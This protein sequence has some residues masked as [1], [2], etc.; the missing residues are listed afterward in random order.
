MILMTIE[1]N[2]L[3][4]KQISTEA[5]YLSTNVQLWTCLAT[6]VQECSLIVSSYRRQPFYLKR[7]PQHKELRCC[8]QQA[9]SSLAWGGCTGEHALMRWK[10]GRRGWGNDME[11]G[12]IMSLG[13]A[14]L[15]ADIR[16]LWRAEGEPSIRNYPPLELPS[17]P[18]HSTS[19]VPGS[20]L[21]H[22]AQCRANV[23]ITGRFSSQEDGGFSE[24]WLQTLLSS[25]ISFLLVWLQSLFR[26]N[27]SL[28]T[29]LHACFCPAD[30]S[31]LKMDAIYSSE[32]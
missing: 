7:V 19:D 28:A 16:G 8:D 30:S 1:I 25:R 13:Q 11:F 2:W 6:Q 10:I 20:N 24:Q 31:V 29:C 15:K 17:S 32:T 21:A 5:Y 3:R 23:F 9:R 12:R 14:Y 4:F 27:V 26:S 22:S 18:H